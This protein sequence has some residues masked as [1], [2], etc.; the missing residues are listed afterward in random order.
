MA[1]SKCKKKQNTI[2]GFDDIPVMEVGGAVAGA[3]AAGKIVELMTTNKD[4][5]PKTDSYLTK[6]PTMSNAV[7]AA[8]GI[9]AIAYSDG[10]E[11]V[12]GAGMGAAIFF[13]YQLAQNLMAKKD[14][15]VA[16]MGYIPPHMIGQHYHYGTTGSGMLPNY[17]AGE[18]RYPI[19]NQQKQMAPQ[20]S[21]MNVKVT[22]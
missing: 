9:A 14:P 19:P 1:C 3:I 4:G 6:N 10:N 11:L 2:A 21:A 8:A 17:V 18:Q 7:G 16:G 12:K 5:T 20:P 15:S 13:G 22:Y